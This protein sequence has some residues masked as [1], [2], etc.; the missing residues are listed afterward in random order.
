MAVLN[1]SDITLD[2]DIE[3]GNVQ[4]I[5]K[6]QSKLPS[7]YRELKGVRFA[8]IKTRN[9][10]P[11]TEGSVKMLFRK[12]GINDPFTA[13]IEDKHGNKATVTIDALGSAR[14]KN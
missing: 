11:T 6:A 9:L 14:V 2:I 8:Y 1:Q 12:T 5:S 10:D 7:F 13:L 4:V 3:T